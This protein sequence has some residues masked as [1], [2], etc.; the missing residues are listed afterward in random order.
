MNKGIENTILAQLS[1]KTFFCLFL[2]NLGRYT[3]IG[4]LLSYVINSLG[5]LTM[6]NF[7]ARMN[8]ILNKSST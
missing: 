3:T 1:L 4:R 6:L 5:K 8:E 2:N 7:S